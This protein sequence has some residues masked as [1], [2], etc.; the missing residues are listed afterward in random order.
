MKHWSQLISEVV[1]CAEVVDCD[2]YVAG[3]W[4]Q[5]FSVARLDEV[6]SYGQL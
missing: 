4:R 6:P 5:A 1:D 2:E 3:Q